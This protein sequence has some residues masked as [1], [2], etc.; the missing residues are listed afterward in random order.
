[1]SGLITKAHLMAITIIFAGALLVSGLSLYRTLLVGV[2]G[3]QT[4]YETA[5]VSQTGNEVRDLT[6]KKHVTFP[7]V[8][9][10]INSGTT[11]LEGVEIHYLQD[12]SDTLYKPMES[13]TI[14]DAPYVLIKDAH[15]SCK[16]QLV[17]RGNKNYLVLWEVRT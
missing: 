6:S 5:M 8:Y 17:Q 2:W 7:R 3:L 11:L 14:Q 9:I 16:V 4:K 13:F 15:K 12:G 1:M 10:V